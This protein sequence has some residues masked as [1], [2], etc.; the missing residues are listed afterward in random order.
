MSQSWDA[1]HRPWPRRKKFLQHMRQLEEINTSMSDQRIA[2]YMNGIAI[3]IGGDSGLRE[4]VVAAANLGLRQH[5]VLTEAKALQSWFEGGEYQQD[6]SKALAYYRLDNHFRLAHLFYMRGL[7]V[8]SF[9]GGSSIKDVPTILGWPLWV[10]DIEHA[11]QTASFCAYCYQ[12]NAFHHQEFHN[13]DA[14]RFM[15][16]LSNRLFDQPLH[17]FNDP[18]QDEVYQSLLTEIAT[19]ND[20]VLLPLLERACNRHTHHSKG[21]AGDKYWDFGLTTLS[22]VPVEI[23]AYIRIRQLEGL[24]TPLP[25]HLLLDAPNNRLLPIGMDLSYT[26]EILETCEA[27][28]KRETPNYESILKEAYSPVAL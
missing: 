28:A 23:W 26:D 2:D 20:A 10:G 25:K 21:D 24:E 5:A 14:V 15:L 9:S 11:K 6:L 22:N 27:R 3:V 4:Q 18:C 17:G 13:N 19:E 7:S 16:H 12:H 1:I 8:P